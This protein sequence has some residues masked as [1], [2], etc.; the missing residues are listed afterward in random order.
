VT[1]LR[2]V[3]EDAPTSVLPVI[4]QAAP[5]RQRRWSDFGLVYGVGLGLVLL[6][7]FLRGIGVVG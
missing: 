4:P 7:P 3:P 2:R 1:I 6:E 5:R